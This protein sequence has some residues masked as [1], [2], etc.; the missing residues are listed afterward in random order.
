V[1]RMIDRMSDTP[2]AVFT[3]AWD[4]VQW[5]PLWGE[6]FGNPS[7]VGPRTQN[8]VWGH[9]A[10]ETPAGVSGVERDAA[11]TDA[12]ER[13]MVSDLRRAADRYPDDR[14]VAELIDALRASSRFDELWARYETL[15]LAGSHKTVVH[16]ELGAITL[17]C[18]ILAIERADL[19]IVM[20][21][22][23]PGTR[24]A[25]KLDALRERGANAAC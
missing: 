19:H 23:V 1:Q 18:D 15:P 14:A 24:D 22:A 4:A 9:F 5:N 13:M 2:V 7:E 8:M 10:A 17:D 12:F 21:W 16:P 11:H 6:L 3:A 20:N 25:E